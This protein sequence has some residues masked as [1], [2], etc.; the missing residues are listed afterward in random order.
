M[1]LK[2]SSSVHYSKRKTLAHLASHTN[3]EM[4]LWE[5]VQAV[6]IY[7]FSFYKSLKSFAQFAPLRFPPDSSLSV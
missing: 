6:I 4:E 7:F 3:K 5:E 1:N 2:L